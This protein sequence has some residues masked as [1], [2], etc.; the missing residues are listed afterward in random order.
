MKRL[1]LLTMCVILSITMLGCSSNQE[2]RPE[3]TEEQ[4][5][6]IERA[7]DDSITGKPLISD[8]LGDVEFD[9]VNNEVGLRV[10]SIESSKTDIDIDV[11]SAYMYFMFF[12]DT[13][14]FTGGIEAVYSSSSF[15][16]E[17]RLSNDGGIRSFKCFLYSV[18]LS[19]GT[20]WGSPLFYALNGAEIVEQQAVDITE[21]FS[22]T[23]F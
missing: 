8:I 10:I 14:E 5:D 12:D 21:Y 16:Y 13:G 11:E 1:L 19:D 6:E 3:V 4:L 22:I 20:S 18:E 15:G 17:E 7:I 23:S 2:E 9:S